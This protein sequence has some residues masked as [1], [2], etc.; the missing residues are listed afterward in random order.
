MRDLQKEI[1]FFWFEQTTPA[2]W[3]QKNPDFDKLIRRQ[4]DSAYDLA[5]AGILEGW[6]DTPE[7]CLAYI[8]LLDQFP[9]NMFRGLPKAFET[10]AK[11]L[12]VA[13]HALHKHFDQTLSINQKRFMYLPFEHSEN[14]ED[15][16]QSVLLFSK[17]RQEDPLGYDYAVRHKEVIQKFG[18]FPQ[19]N[20]ALGRASTKE[21]LR[22]LSDPANLF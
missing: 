18:R 22:F 15:Q 1:L 10:D 2:Q 5:R 12:E 17:L 3:F 14:L 4:F 16:E 13:R 8:I 7:G 19:R 20:E 6:K 21:E 9:R 11:A